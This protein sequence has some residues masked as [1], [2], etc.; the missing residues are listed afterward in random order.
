M[1]SSEPIPG[2]PWPHDMVITIENAP[3]MLHE[4]LWIREAW[5]L[6]VTGADL[7]PL[8]TNTPAP[9]DAD[10]PAS[11][12][13]WRDGWAELWRECLAHAGE[14]HDPLMFDRLTQ[15]AIGS[16]DRTTLLGKLRGPSWR[17]RFGDE[18]LTEAFDDWNRAQFETLTSG[19]PQPYDESPERKS[20][21]VLITAWRGGL[22]KL[23]LI[24]CRGTFTRPIG[25]SS[26]LLTDETRNDPIRY[27]EALRSVGSATKESR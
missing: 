19:L 3:H 27:S 16:D 24:P 7:P 17:D 8:L 13:E 6:R 14:V 2:N 9:A 26:L 4:L 15:S 20:L 5:N 1:R 11:I 18:A 12:A 23:V 10:R 21:D 25:Q 22:T